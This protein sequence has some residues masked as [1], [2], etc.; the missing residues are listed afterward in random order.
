MKILH[1]LN[2]FLP[3]NIAGTEV[4]TASLIHL[5]QLKNINSVVV[6]P[7]YGNHH[8][9]EYNVQG[10]RVIQY[11]EPSIVDRKLMM[12]KR[13]PDGL[14]AFK[15]V[16]QSEKPD[17]V[18]FHVIG[19]SNSI[20]KHHL[21]VS[22]KMGFKIIITFHIAGY[23]CKTG[24]LMY[25]E[26]VP[27]DG[28]INIKKCTWCNY[29]VRNIPIIKK[30]LLYA[31]SMMGYKLNYD[32]SNWPSQI[33]TALG[34][35][36]IIRQL[37]NDLLQMAANTDKM[38]VLSNWYKNVLLK[39]GIA[40]D[41]LE[42]IT[43]GLPLQKTND[44]VTKIKIVEEIKLVFI[45]RIIE[46]KGLHLLINAL[47]QL[48]QENVSLDI[49]GQINDNAYTKECIAQSADFKNI[50][51]KGRLLSNEVV[52]TFRNYDLLCVPSTICEMS[53]LVIQEAFTAGIPVL[54][55]EVYG[56]AEQ[57]KDNVNGW[58]FKFKSSDDL[59]M[60]LQQ[61]IAEPERI[62][63]AKKNI[64]SVKSFSAVADEYEQL[65]N[66]IIILPTKN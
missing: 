2:H 15:N 50:K 47:K 58:L 40:E 43:Q 22:K 1:C 33:G 35:P 44:A 59:K 65:Y 41:K 51:W 18:H 66:K 55:S 39:N 26:E 7:N 9:E 62:T 8:T 56:N 21:F 29:T 12:G 16:L 31:S 32:T 49:Y 57:I 53:P 14:N 20:T 27:C 52:S 28:I 37:K 46:S 5:L 13:I 54:A 61:L 34:F 25:K 24:N 23:S 3:N 48:P 30:H 17:I 19:M 42:L 6:I 38:V 10:I 64:P 4:Y 63:S 36:F 45:G 60:K 11:S